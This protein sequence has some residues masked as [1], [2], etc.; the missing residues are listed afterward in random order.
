MTSGAYSISKQGLEKELQ[1]GPKTEADNRNKSEATTESVLSAENSTT[2]EG[3]PRKESDEKRRMLLV[4]GK[5]SE[6]V[7]VDDEPVPFE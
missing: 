4:A 7:L 6:N 3:K 5:L 1:L 2:H